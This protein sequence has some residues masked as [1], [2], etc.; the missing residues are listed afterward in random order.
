MGV[1]AFSILISIFILSE[2]SYMLCHCNFLTS[3][4]SICAS[5]VYTTYFYKIT[6]KVLSASGLLQTNKLSFEKGK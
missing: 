2:F 6:G 1:K 3:F 4:G 5:A